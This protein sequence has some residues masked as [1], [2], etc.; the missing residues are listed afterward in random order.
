MNTR[1]ALV[2]GRDITAEKVARFLPSNYSV[3]D[4]DVVGR[5]GDTVVIEG[6][7]SC[8]WTLDDYVL[9]RLATGGMYGTEVVAS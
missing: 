6:Q 4:S 1:I 2:A 8:G 7:D 9:P 3:V 5:D